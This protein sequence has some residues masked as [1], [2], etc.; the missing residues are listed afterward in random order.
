[1]RRATPTAQTASNFGLAT[2]DWLRQAIGRA[3]RRAKEKRV[4]ASGHTAAAESANGAIT[5][6]TYHN[7]NA[8]GQQKAAGVN[9]MRCNRRVRY[10]IPGKTP[11]A[12]PGSEKPGDIMRFR[13]FAIVAGL[14]VA[15][16]AL[17]Q[18]P[19]SSLPPAPTAHHSERASAPSQKAEAAP[20]AAPTPAAKATP[21]IDPAKETAIRHLMDI[22]NTSKLG[23]NM[24]QYIS[25]QVRQY[26][27]R[28]LDPTTLPKFMDSFNQKFFQ[29]AS[30]KNVTDAMVPIY[31]HAFSKQE[32]DGLVQ[33]YESPLGQHVV[34]VLPQVL[35]QS[36]D[37]A[38]KMDQEAA[39]NVLRGMS[40]DYP[41]L[42]QMLPAEHQPPAGGAAPSTQQPA[43]QP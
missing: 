27:S 34:K 25:N 30:S 3:R 18:A 2:R 36:Q 33:F 8:L 12:Q 28:S 29:S 32:I 35:Q 10:R 24:A 20:K 4:L 14:C 26:M 23:D 31:D 7:V 9:C 42:K 22:T 37:A 38:A 1:M 19:S 40:N 13:I 5:F 16:P 41:Q 21:K 43:P 39:L 6:A 15:G 11:I 17:A